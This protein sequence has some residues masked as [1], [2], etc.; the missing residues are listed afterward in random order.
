[1]LAKPKKKKSRSKLNKELTDLAKLY[2][3]QLDG[4]KCQHCGKIVTGSNAHGS[5][6]YP[7]SACKRLSF[8]Y[9]NIKTLC[10]HC[11][12]NWWHKNPI[13]AKDWYAEKFPDR[14]AYLEEKMFE[15]K[16]C[17]SLP[18]YE[19]E[20]MIADYKEKIKRLDKNLLF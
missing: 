5:H 14:L 19:L 11:H 10:Y 4:W 18:L 17:G 8:D 16:D 7:V 2:R 1:M 20:E 13:E 15:Y 3:K 12:M 6:V 9:V